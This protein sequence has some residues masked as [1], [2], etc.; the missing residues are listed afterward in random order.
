MKL[1]YTHPHVQR[2]FKIAFLCYNPIVCPLYSKGNLWL[3]SIRDCRCS[4]LW[5]LTSC[6]LEKK[7]CNPVW[8]CS[9]QGNLEGN[10][11]SASGLMPSD[12]KYL[13]SLSL[14]ST[15]WYTLILVLIKMLHAFKYNFKL[16]YKILQFFQSYLLYYKIFLAEKKIIMLI[17]FELHFKK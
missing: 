2:S 5:F 3:K 13:G 11:Q 16:N 7:L 17:S 1:K 10:S 4:L 6:N 8:F 12:R 9:L 15:S 14:T